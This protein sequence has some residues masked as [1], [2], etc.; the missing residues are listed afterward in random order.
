MNERHIIRK[1]NMPVREMIAWVTVAYDRGVAIE[2]AADDLY[3]A[4]IPMTNSDLTLE[5]AQAAYLAAKFAKEN[6]Q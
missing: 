6:P 3:N 5:Q 4:T 1:P 2:Q